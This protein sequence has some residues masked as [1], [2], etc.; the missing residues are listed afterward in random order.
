MKED[1][2]CVECGHQYEELGDGKCYVCGGDIIPI[3][4]VGQQEEAEYPED[5][6]EETET[7]PPEEL[8]DWEEPSEEA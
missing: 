2:V 8:E 6:M 1:Y 3:E 7:T 5:L 4:E